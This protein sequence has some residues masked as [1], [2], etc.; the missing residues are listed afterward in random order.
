MR[1]FRLRSILIASALQHPQ[2]ALAICL[3][4]LGTAG[5][6]PCNRGSWAADPIS[7]TDFQRNTSQFRFWMGAC[8]QCQL[9][10]SMTKQT[11]MLSVFLCLQR[12]WI[13]ACCAGSKSKGVCAAAA[14]S[15]CLDMVLV[16][17]CQRGDK[18]CW[19]N[20]FIIPTQP[21]G[22]TIKLHPNQG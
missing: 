3:L 14:A 6:G 11:V 13:Y 18:I 10:K 7:Q 17:H 20:C 22:N 16:R 12:D 2:G 15:S 8:T 21:E 5:T 19:E 4:V 1:F 9:H